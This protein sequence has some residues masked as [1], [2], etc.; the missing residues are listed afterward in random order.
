MG[1]FDRFKKSKEQE[2]NN[3]VQI[4]NI[5]F[6]FHINLYKIDFDEENNE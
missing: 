5:K 1:L 3:I 2:N 6:P 4:Y